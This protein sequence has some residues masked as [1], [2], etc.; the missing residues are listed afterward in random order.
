[1]VKQSDP[2]FTIGIPTF[3]R[4]E[5]LK[6]TLQS[7]LNQTYDDF[8]IIISNDYVN[9]KL[10]EK[11]IGISDKRIRI[12]NQKVNLGE[13]GNMNFLLSKARGKYFTW[14]FDDDIYSSQFLELIESLLSQQRNILCVYSGVGY[15]YGRKYPNL[16]SVKN[17]KKTIYNGKKFVFDFLKGKVSVAGCCGVFDKVYLI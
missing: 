17:V 3:N 13:A 4:V 10:T 11:S 1:M 8:E 9:E 6:Q 16:K 12:Y 14:Q 15:I 5:L 7:I 2:L